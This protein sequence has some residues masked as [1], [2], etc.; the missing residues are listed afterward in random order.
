MTPDER[1]ILT[2][3]CDDLSRARASQRDPEAAD[4][5]ARAL[6]ANPDGAY[7]LVQHA[8]VRRPVAPRRASPHRRTRR[9]TALTPAQQRPQRLSRPHPQPLEP[10][11]QLASRKHRPPKATSPCPHNNAPACSRRKAASAASCAAP[12]PPRPEWPAAKCCSA[13]S[14]TSSA[15]A[16]AGGGREEVINNYYDDDNGGGSFD[17]ANNFDGHHVLGSAGFKGKVRGVIPSRS[18]SLAALRLVSR[19][20]ADFA[21]ELRARKASRI[22]RC[23]I[24]AKI[25]RYA[26]FPVRSQNAHPDVGRKR[27]RDLFVIGRLENLELLERKV[28]CQ[29]LRV[30]PIHLGFFVFVIKRCIES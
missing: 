9:P 13:A 11:R 12:A 27:S 7:V 19:S 5:I 26:T 17:N 1:T 30:Y 10:G 20:C 2:R 14:A 22:Q 21:P 18:P 24:G 29:C 6:A 8:V 15:A 16:T 23:K 25:L 3:F 28:G 4:L